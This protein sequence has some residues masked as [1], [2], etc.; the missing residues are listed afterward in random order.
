MSWV[1]A[2]LAVV[3]AVVLLVVVVLA[4]APTH[5]DSWVGK[6]IV[7]VKRVLIVGCTDRN[8]QAANNAPQEQ[9]T[10]TVEAEKS[11]WVQVRQQGVLA[12]QRSEASKFSR[13]FLP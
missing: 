13:S 3:G 10:Y 8:G 6:R 11:R 9:M 12:L 7:T 2:C 4:L 1:D 5:A